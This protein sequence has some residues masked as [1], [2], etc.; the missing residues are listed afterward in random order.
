MKI[1]ITLTLLLSI[2][3]LAQELKIKANS[4]NADEKAGIS[5]FSGAVNIIKNKDELNASKVTIHTNKEHTPTK[6]IAIGDVS[7]QISTKKG[8]IYSGHAQKVIYLPQ[9]KEYKFFEDVRLSQVD[10][11]KEIIGDEV[12]LN[13]VE[14]KA[15][16]KGQESG[17]VIMI[18]HIPDES[19]EK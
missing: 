16:A 19:E 2:S 18:F 3:L 4:F 9:D 11:K 7:F 5:M 1:M 12:V 8:A 17:P 10:D 14:G 13:T 6:Y 15:Y